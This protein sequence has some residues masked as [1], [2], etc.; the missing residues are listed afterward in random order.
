MG[1]LWRVVFGGLVLR[2]SEISQSAEDFGT[3]SE[4]F[5]GGGEGHAEVGI[6]GTEHGAGDDE[7]IIADGF[8]NEFSACAP[9]SFEEEVEGSFAAGDCVAVFEK[10]DEEVAFAAIVPAVVLEIEFPCSDTGPLHGVWRANEGELLEFQHLLNEAG[11]AV[12]EP[13]P[14]SGHGM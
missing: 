2:R 7:E 5:V 10:A 4:H 11:G 6:V 8:G 13:K 3:F 12:H 9:G 14:Q 1:V